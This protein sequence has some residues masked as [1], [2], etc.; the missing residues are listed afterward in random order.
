MTSIFAMS[1]WTQKACNNG[2]IANIKC[3]EPGSVDSK[4]VAIIQ[5]VQVYRRA[6]IE[7]RL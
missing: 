6:N 1:P 3:V 2:G 5:V 4:R 7:V